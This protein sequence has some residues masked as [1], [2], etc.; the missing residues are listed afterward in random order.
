M[1]A[2]LNF[3]GAHGSGVARFIWFVSF[4]RL[5]QMD[6]IDQINQMNKIGWWDCSASC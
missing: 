4:V 6:Q 1:L 5:N 2:R 3:D